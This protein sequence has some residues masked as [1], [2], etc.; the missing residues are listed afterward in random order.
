MR[1][2]ARCTQV[3]RSWTKII[4]GGEDKSPLVNQECVVYYFQCNLDDA[5]YVGYTYRRLHQRI[6]EHKGS[7]IGNL[8]T[9]QHNIAPN[10]TVRTFKILRKCQNK[11]DCLIFVT[12]FFLS[13]NLNQ[14]LTNR[15]IPSAQN[16]LIISVLSKPRYCS[17]VSL[18]YVLF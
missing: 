1:I 7:A 15:V 5:G 8:L 3:E 16:Y 13:K 14:H 11:L 12:L 6:E 17:I 4:K 2:S 18:F 10:G 9:E